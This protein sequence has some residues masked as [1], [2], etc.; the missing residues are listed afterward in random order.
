[1]KKQLSTLFLFTVVALAVFSFS[2][3]ALRAAED[4]Q[5]ISTEDLS[6]GM[7]NKSLFVVD[8]NTP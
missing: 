5:F 8:C 7:K 1:M 3:P 4:L 6:Q 2:T